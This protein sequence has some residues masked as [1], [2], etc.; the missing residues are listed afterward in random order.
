M[1]PLAR[2]HGASCA[3]MS[4]LLVLAG[5]LVVTAGPLRAQSISGLDEDKAPSD[6]VEL[7]ETL[8]TEWGL[9]SVETASGQEAP[10]GIG[11]ELTAGRQTAGATLDAL[12]TELQRA[13]K[14]VDAGDFSDEQR[15][16]MK[17]AATQAERQIRAA[18]EGSG[19]AGIL[20]AEAVRAAFSDY[21]SALEAL[22]ARRG[23]EGVGEGDEPR[24]S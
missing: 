14:L 21:L 3:A 2:K 10:W 22:I 9:H 4:V 8:R 20:P 17:K 1:N 5:A 11:D 7:L 16:A 24:G 6:P 13:V 19:D 12:L 18:V 23:V 15:G